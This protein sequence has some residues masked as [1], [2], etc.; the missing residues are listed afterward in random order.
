MNNSAANKLL[1]ILEEPPE[2]TLFFLICDSIE[3]IL[4]T[5]ISRTQIIKIPTL[6]LEDVETYLT[7][8]LKVPVEQAQSITSLTQG[9]VAEAIQ[10]ANGDSVSTMYFDSFVKLMRAAYK[11][12]ALALMEIGEELA[13]YDRENQKNFLKYGLHIFR[14]S[15]IFNYMGPEKV[16]LNEQ[17]KDFLKKFARFINN[18]NISPLIDEFNDSI[19]HIDRN[20]NAKLLFSDL[21][22]KLTKLIKKGV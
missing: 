21:V 17:E 5:I 10:I 7:K 12:D 18:Q 6:K 11:I 20:A 22:I 16:N 9:N 1:K 3:L 8:K 14:E 19:Y 2:K 4:P 13:N 15:L